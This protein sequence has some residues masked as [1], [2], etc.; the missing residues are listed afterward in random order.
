MN[1]VDGSCEI[2]IS[3]IDGL[4][5]VMLVATFPEYKKD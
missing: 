2:T 4:E 3:V 1:L 5:Q